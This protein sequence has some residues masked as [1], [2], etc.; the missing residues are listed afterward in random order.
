MKIS[1]LKVVLWV[2]FRAPVVGK[3]GRW[4]AKKMYFHKQPVPFE[5]PSDLHGLSL[6]FLADPHMGGS[7]DTIVPEVIEGM[8]V[9]LSETDPE[10]T[11]IMHGGDF[12]CG[13]SGTHTATS[14]I[15]E[16]A[17]RLFGDL[18]PYK[19]FAVVGNHDEE[20]LEFPRM[21]HYLE[22]V[23]GVHF[24][25]EPAHS[26]TL[27]I[28]ES[29][30]LVQGIHTLLNRLQTMKKAE[31][32]VLLDAYIHLLNRSDIDFH[33]VLL[34]NPDGLQYLLR[35]LV[36]T[37]TTIT[38]PTLFLAGHTHGSTLN[39]P[40]IRHGALRVCK[41][42]Y[43]RYMGW[44]GPKGKYVDT[45]NWQLYVSTGMGNSPGF[46]FRINARQEVILFTL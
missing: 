16:I 36:E 12:I 18:L 31:R 27:K 10:K 32:D 37:N 6:L 46:D 23:F 15:T 44:Y 9:L 7:I 40:I 8:N 2:A 13:H 35:R 14:E 26:Q 30:V 42:K 5:V 21:R 24:M 17:G 43:G 28:G 38:T 34:H 41:T 39:L 25:T 1:L 22:D 33:V 45:G 20:D 3:R 29:Q 19:H 11:C 4:N